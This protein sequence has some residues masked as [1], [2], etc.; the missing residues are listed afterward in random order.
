MRF[1]EYHN[2]VAVIKDKA[3]LKD[4]MQRLAELEDLEEQG[5]LLKLPVAEGDTVY[6]IITRFECDCD[7]ECEEYFQFKCEDDMPCEHEYEVHRVMEYE[8]HKEILGMLGKTIFLTRAEA[9]K[10]LAEMEK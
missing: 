8:F 1:T 5:L 10:A 7:Y 4:A 2:G 9:E 3:L 6:K